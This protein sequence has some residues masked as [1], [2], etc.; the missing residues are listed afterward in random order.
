MKMIKRFSRYLASVLVTS[1]WAIHCAYASVDIAS[2]PLQ[3]G[4]TVPPN[5]MFILDD[6]G[7]MQFEITPED[8]TNGQIYYVFPRA[9]GVYG[10]GD[11]NHFVVS[12]RG[13]VYAYSAAARSFHFNSNYY[14]PAVTYSPWINSNGEYFDD[15]DPECAWHNPMREGSCPGSLTTNSTNSWARNLT[16]D[17]NKYNGANWVRCTSGGNCYYDNDRDADQFWPATYYF[18]NGGGQWNTSSYTKVEIK[19]A[20]STYTSHGRENRSDCVDGT[21]TYQQ[22][23][24][25]FANWYTFYRSR[26]L[27]ARAGVGLAFVSQSDKMRVGFATLNKGGS[28][29]DGSYTDVIVQ[30]VREFSGAN[31][32]NFYNQL[33]GRDIP[34]A[35]TPLRAALDAA[36]K[37]FSRSDSLGPWGLF[38]GEG[39][40]LSTDHVTCRQSFSILM[41]DGYWSGS[42]PSHIDEQDNESGQWI[43][44]PEGEQGDRYRYEPSEPF[45]SSRSDTLADVAMK[46]WKNDLRPDLENRVP[47]STIDPAF[48]QHMVTFGIGFGVFGD[49]DPDEAFAAINSGEDIDWPNP[50][51]SEKAKLDDLLHASVNGR[52]GYF[53]AANPEQFAARLE[54]TLTSILDRVAS[55][56]NLAG[57]TTST[58]AE[59]YVYQGSFNSGAWSGSL[60]SFNIDNPTIPVWESTFPAWSSRKIIFGQ[61][62]GSAAY[63]NPTN[64]NADGNALAGN[65]DLVNYLRGDRSFETGGGA[66]FRSRVSVMG[67][68]ANSSPLYVANS[69]NR[70]FQRYNWSGASSYRAFIQSTQARTP[71]IF[72]G[73]N[74]GLFHGF[75]AQTGVE[76]I[77]YI[78]TGVLT[79]SANLKAYSDLNYDHDYFVDG[80]ASVFD[81]FLD[82]QWET[83]VIGSLGRGGNSLFALNVTDTDELVSAPTSH[84][85]WDKQYASL[86]ITINKPIVA[87]LNNGKWAVIVGYGYNGSS[88]KAGLLV[89][90]I[91]DGSVI[92]SIETNSDLDNGLGRVE[93]WDYNSDGNLDWFFAGDLHGNVWKFDLSSSNAADWNI[94]NNGTP[95]Y[96]ARDADGN[97]Q[98]ITGGVTLSAEP[99][100]GYLWM[101]FGTG[102]M[103]SE[104]DPLSSIQNT[105]YGIK[106]GVAFS[107]RNNLIERDIIYTEDDAR[108]IEYGTRLEMFSKRGWYIE[109]DEPRERIINTPQILGESLVI[110]TITPS[111]SECN[112]QG[113]GWVLSVDAYTG[114]RLAYNFF[115]RNRD[116]NVDPNDSI[117]VPGDG[118][119]DNQMTPVSGIRFDGMPSEPVFFEDKMVVGLSDTR[120]STINIERNL[121]KGRVSWREITDK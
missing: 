120:I 82:G 41:T 53:T 102:R 3:T 73:S 116:T 34:A 80:S 118:D 77:A 87:R 108:V 1:L 79:E 66:K 75:N 92:R 13:D 49:V 10:S 94:A 93:G 105:W 17:N 107:G 100:T 23:I 96:V 95:L 114:G 72:V 26:I 65:D 32:A 16:V 2:V 70:N 119:N 69:V 98:P 48:W 36:G 67:D 111:F 18:Y 74:D 27:S 57:T 71:M 91:E 4:S 63:F 46:Y 59:N 83:V 9:S 15:A 86:G 68:I 22:E 113:R 78:P 11:Y 52:G 8:L 89:I 106:D 90:D 101:Y 99:Q 85:M 33:Y 112:P 117:S 97:R 12:P 81:V 54:R 51:N 21:C 45:R 115:D 88:G 40:E 44:R 43:D 35:G 29:V 42:T 121:R 6:S 14:N 60:K 37:Y 7:S 55:A 56:T 104:G 19:S 76:Q 47:T 64:V 58:Q 84:V 20:Q 30:G 38:P 109:L 31:K 25:N 5:I 62:N 103:L 39:N 61:T 28:F 110:N 50:F 24:Q